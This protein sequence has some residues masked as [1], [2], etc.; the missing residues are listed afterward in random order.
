M[1]VALIWGVSG[2][3]SLTILAACKVRTHSLKLPIPIFGEAKVDNLHCKL[4]MWFH[5]WDTQNLKP[6]DATSHFCAKGY[7]PQSLQGWLEDPEGCGQDV[8]GPCQHHQW[9]HQE[10]QTH[11]RTQLDFLVELLLS[12]VSVLWIITSVRFVVCSGLF[13]KF[14][15]VFCRTKGLTNL[16]IYNP[17]CKYY[18]DFKTTHQNMFRSMTL[19]NW[20]G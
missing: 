9:T 4:K 10:D 18:Q 1:H 16:F 19:F 15:M 2:L 3:N 20:Y 8:Q 14:I 17:R 12:K 5:H 6:E 7:C 13:C 11:Q